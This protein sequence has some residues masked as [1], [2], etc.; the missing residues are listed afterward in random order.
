MRA[1]FKL[2]NYTE[3]IKREFFESMFPWDLIP[4]IASLMTARGPRLG[5]GPVWSV[6]RGDVINFFGYNFAILIFHTRDPKEDLW[7]HESVGK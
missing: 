3:K 6:S 4:E 7:L 5:C 2:H 1:E